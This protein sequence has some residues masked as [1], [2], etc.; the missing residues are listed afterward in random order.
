MSMLLTWNLRK[1]CNELIC[2]LLGFKF[3]DMMF[4]CKIHNMMLLGVFRGLEY[5]QL[6]PSPHC[7]KHLNVSKEFTFDVIDGIHT[8]LLYYVLTCVSVILNFQHS[9][10][11]SF[12]HHSFSTI[13]TLIRNPSKLSTYT[14]FPNNVFIVK[15]SCAS[16]SLFWVNM[17]TM[18]I[19][20]MYIIFIFLGRNDATSWKPILVGNQIVTN[21]HCC[22]GIFST[23][24]ILISIY[25]VLVFYI[26]M[27][28]HK[29]LI[30]DKK[31]DGFLFMG[32][33]LHDLHVDFKK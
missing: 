26:G 30:V 4:V 11:F 22:M 14:Y 9:Q 33:I 3:N 29:G 23:I 24:A 17:L 28:A 5:P 27:W 20:C 2:I 18:W 7:N 25:V 15:C 19:W 32:S 8:S 12:S 31:F 16:H 21:I 10:W 13:L 6:W 1:M